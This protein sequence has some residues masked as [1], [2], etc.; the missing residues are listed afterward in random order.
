MA[1]KDPKEKQK[2]LVA[3]GKAFF[4]LGKSI[5]QGSMDKHLLSDF[6]TL[7]SMGVEKLKQ[8]NASRIYISIYRQVRGSGCKEVRA[9]S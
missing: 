3:A 7:G 1:L 5:L 4:S 2:A 8:T 6:A 9:G